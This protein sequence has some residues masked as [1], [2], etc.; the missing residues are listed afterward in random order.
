V[1]AGVLRGDLQQSNRPSA[2]T[3]LRQGREN[4]GKIIGKSYFNGKTIGK[5]SKNGGFIWLSMV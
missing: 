2:S 1:A 3:Q 5:P 4:N